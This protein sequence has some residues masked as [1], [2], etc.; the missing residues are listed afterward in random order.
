[1]VNVEYSQAIAE[2]LDILEHTKK[3][4]VNK[5][6]PAFMQFLKENCSE[7]Y[8]P[9]LDHYKQIKDMNL[10]EKTIGI[11]CV[12]NSKFW[13]TNEQRKKFDKKLNENEM[14]YQRELIEKYNPDKLFENKA[15]K[16]E[17]EK[18]SISIVQYKE[19][20][21]SKIK[22]WLKQITKVI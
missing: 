20:I 2:V 11:L 8:K 16:V 13:C 6:S 7:E 21:F 18:N 22:K 1:M 17:I 14:K 9:N 19:S 4:D 15:K 5:I 12:I 10:K 3:E